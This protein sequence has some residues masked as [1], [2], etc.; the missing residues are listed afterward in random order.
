MSPAPR[1]DEVESRARAPRCR[2]ESRG[3][4]EGCRAGTVSIRGAISTPWR[5]AA[6]SPATGDVSS[7]TTS[8]SSATIRARCGSRVGPAFRDWR[9]PLAAP[10]RWTPIFFLDDAVALA[11]GHRPCAT[12]RG[13]D[14]RSYRDAV[15]TAT[16]TADPLLARQLDVR[17]VAERHRRGRGLDRAGDR[18]VWTAD[19]AMLPPGTVVL[20]ADEKSAPPR[21]RSSHGVHLRRLARSATHARRSRAGAHAADVGRRAARRVQPSAASER[22]WLRLSA[23]TRTPSPTSSRIDR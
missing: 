3:T 12:C 11:A 15:T 22:G 17:L 1:R 21:R 4:L 20:D 2:Q 5:P 23:C 6:C 8:G 14:Y 19:T 7:T 9:H 10:R 13:D 16:G 18:L